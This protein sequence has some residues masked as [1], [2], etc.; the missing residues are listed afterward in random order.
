MA[1]SIK[2]KFHWYVISPL[3]CPTQSS[4]PRLAL[5]YLILFHFVT[6]SQCVGGSEKKPRREEKAKNQNPIS[7]LMISEEG[8]DPRVCVC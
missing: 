7:S 6:L 3:P 2:Q 4:Q 8:I 5:Y 1:P